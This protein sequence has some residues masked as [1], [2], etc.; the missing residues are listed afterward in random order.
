MSKAKKNR[1]NRNEDDDE[2]DA[3]LILA[4]L[5]AQEKKI[6]G[7]ESHHTEM[8]AKTE[9]MLP[10]VETEVRLKTKSEKEREKKE[11]LKLQKKQ[12]A[13]QKPKTQKVELADEVAEDVAIPEV[14]PVDESSVKKV[15]KKK[16]GGA[17]AALREAM[18]LRKIQE[19]AEALAIEQEKQRLID[20]ELEEKRK[21][22]AI[23]EARLKK[24]EREREKIVEL[25]KQG[26]YLTAAQKKEQVIQKVRLEALLASG[27]ISVD[28]LKHTENNDRDSGSKKKIVYDSKKKKN[29]NQ[30][31]FSQDT[32]SI[33]KASTPI[34]K[35]AEIIEECFDAIDAPTDADVTDEWDA[36]S[37]DAGET[38]N[39]VEESLKTK[40]T[41]DSK[42]TLP[43]TNIMV[44]AE[45]LK[46]P[47]KDVKAHSKTVDHQKKGLKNVDGLNEKI[48]VAQSSKDGDSIDSQT[49]VP[50]EFADEVDDLSASQ[51]Q[52][53]KEESALRR[54]ARIEAAQSES[55]P[56]NLRSP[57]CCI[58]GHVDT[59]KTKLLDKIRKTNVQDGEAG[60]ITQQIGATFF[61]IASIIEKTKMMHTAEVPHE[62]ILPG[63]LVID[64]PGHESFS[65]LRSRGESLCNI[66]V[67]VVDIVHGL[68][69]QTI[70]S[71]NLLRSR[72][73]PFIVALNKI[74]RLFDWKIHPD[75]PTRQTLALQPSH[76]LQ[77]FDTRL[78][79]TI[80][81]FAEQG[82]N[83][84]LYWDNK[85]PGKTVSLIPTSAHTG[86]GIPDLLHM[87]V[88]LTQS[89]MTN[90]LMYL[91]T[92]EA[93]VLEVKVIE[94]LGTTIDIVIT[95]GI[96]YEGDTICLCGLNGPIVTNIRALLTP[97]PLKELRVKGTYVHNK[98]VRASLGVKISA[99][100]LEKTVAGARLMRV[101][102]G[103]D[104]EEIGEVVMQDLQNLLTTVDKSGKG[105]LVQAS[106]LGSLEALLSFLDKSQIPVSGVNIGP[107]HKKDVIRASVMVERA[108]Q[109]AQLLCFDV[110]I[111]K[112]AELLAKEMGVRIFS[113]D[114]IYHLFDAYTAYMSSV[115]EAKKA[116][117]TPTAVFPC[118]LRIVPDAC[119]NK[120]DPIIIGVDVIE[121]SL[122]VGTPLCVVN[123]VSYAL[124]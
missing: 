106:T 31:H 66:A 87:L 112:D 92:L 58:L 3:E 13:A 56:T 109:Y 84:E 17:I 12:Q 44:K 7:P 41:K 119:F 70:E 4:R 71:L 105:V 19:E 2:D 10:P 52:A 38:W 110:E 114:I 102:E 53:L 74:D 121:G 80:L 103:D 77:E 75:Y 8:V 124:I 30:H 69:P 91:S 113:A 86:E 101:E 117:L 22:M 107:V 82:L 9:D 24:K 29:P 62:Y 34:A 98:S 6:G 33:A 14:C 59:G 25:K 78:K 76:V 99:P 111:E 90:Q 55:D 45:K 85:T 96:L 27:G 42:K 81:E 21:E 89:R 123:D 108:P 94:G 51:R 57:I 116:A 20:I 95:N 63:L 11:R 15:G 49:M 18:Q 68:E 93:T 83:A 50:A 40:T 115:E 65:N 1:K 32:H 47:L 23:E 43:D 16:G 64:T 120:R 122:K 60:G 67:L 79:R 54:K 37:N 28:A 61:P 26:L 48:V 118:T 73:T 46:L 88:T 39:N 72:K 35:P 36:E 104:L 100:G 5:D 97:Q